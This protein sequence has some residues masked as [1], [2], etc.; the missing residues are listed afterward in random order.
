MTDVPTVRAVALDVKQQEDG[1]FICQFANGQY[2]LFWGRVVHPHNDFA[3]VA[4]NARHFLERQKE[5]KLELASHVD[6]E[7]IMQHGRMHLRFRARH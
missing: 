6:P 4:K 3:T 5:C 2:P 7:P 1:T